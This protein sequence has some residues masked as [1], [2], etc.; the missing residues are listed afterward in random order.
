MCSIPPPAPRTVILSVVACSVDFLK[1]LLLPEQ[2]I[3]A[4][5][6][7]SQSP[8]SPNALEIL[9]E[10]KPLP[11]REG[12]GGNVEIKAQIASQMPELLPGEDTGERGE[13][14]RPPGGEHINGKV[15]EAPP[16]SAAY[17]RRSPLAQPQHHHVNA[18]HGHEITA[19]E[20]MHGLDLEP[21]LEQEGAQ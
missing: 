8:I 4:A 12:C 2:T 1:S 21:G 13:Q 20:T 19:P 14:G 15:A 18:R 11:E 10:A 16:F 6:Y 9:E 3:L 17:Q 7:R 5:H